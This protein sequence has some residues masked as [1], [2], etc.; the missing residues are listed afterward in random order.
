MIWK[1]CTRKRSWPDLGWPA[2]PTL[3]RRGVQESHEESEGFV[4]PGRDWN[5]T[6]PKYEVGVLSH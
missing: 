4:C 1:E 3:S 2:I 6:S 5:Q